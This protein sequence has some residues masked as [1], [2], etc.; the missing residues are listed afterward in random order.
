MAA[1]RLSGA[2]ALRAEV[3]ELL[4]RAGL[5]T[6]LDPAIETDAILAALER[7]KKA[8]AEGVPF[9]LVERPGEATTGARLGAD[10]VRSAVDELKGSTE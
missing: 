6:E 8:D 5:P 4:T 10:M 7:D 1:L 9:V 3:G 2:D